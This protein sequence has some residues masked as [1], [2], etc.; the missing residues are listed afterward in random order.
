VKEDEKSLRVPSF[1]AH[2]T[3]GLIR[4]TRARRKIL[5][6]V[7]SGA[8]LL[9]VAGST[10]LE[11]ALNPREHA[12]AFIIFWIACAW[13]TA[14]SILL[15]LFDLLMVRREARAERRQRRA[16]LTQ[17]PTADSPGKPLER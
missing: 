8:L 11:N 12:T 2:A 9:M 4:D 6:V 16:D 15:A 7:I 10:F 5:M 14:L 1:A 3:R 17:E 13:L